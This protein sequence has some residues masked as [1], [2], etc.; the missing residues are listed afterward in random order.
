MDRIDD[1]QEWLDT[2]GIESSEGVSSNEDG[3]EDSLLVSWS[4]YPGPSGM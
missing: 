3:D 4:D 2:F 1:L